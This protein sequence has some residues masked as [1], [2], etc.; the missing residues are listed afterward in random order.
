LR[1]Y[2]L[3]FCEIFK[4]K[5]WGGRAI[6]SVLGK[7]LPPGEK[8]GESWELADHFGDVSIVRNGHL[9]GQTLRFIWR[10]DPKAILGEALAQRK[11]REFPL[12][13][14]FIDAAEDLSVQVHPDQAYVEKHDSGGESGKNESWIVLAATRGAELVAGLRQGVG[15]EELKS[16]A[17]NGTVGECLNRVRVKA[18]DVIHIGAGTVHSIGK[19]ILVCEIQQTSDAT[20]RIWDYGRLGADGKPRPLHIE[21]ALRVTDFGLGPVAPLS[22]VEQSREPVGRSTLD[23]CPSYVIERITLASGHTE[24]CPEGRFS[25]MVCTEGSGS[26]LADGDRVSYARGDTFLVPAAVHSIVLEPAE[27]TAF[28]KAYLPTGVA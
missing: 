15:R 19:G 14:K 17:K 13:V 27:Q 21:D 2:P 20:Y 23:A 9:E 7:R 26:M 12:L 10:K 11:F 5:I 4:P 8:I 16:A 3:K 28:L 1:L 25:I 6:E 18:G 24:A 22:P